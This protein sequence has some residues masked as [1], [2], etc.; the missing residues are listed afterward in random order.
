MDS[1]QIWIWTLMLTASCSATVCFADEPVQSPGTAPLAGDAKPTP[2]PAI[3]KPATEAA[4]ASDAGSA[5]TPT[6]A[7]PAANAGSAKPPTEAAPVA[8][9]PLCQE[10][11]PGP[12]LESRKA[13][14]ADIKKA[15]AQGVGIAG[16]LT[17]FQGIEEQIKAG[18]PPDQL[19]GRID[20][21]KR[22]LTEQL[23]RSQL[24]KVQKPAP[25]QGS[26]VSGSGSASSA[27]ASLPPPS[28]SGG[29]GPDESGMLAKLKRKFGDLNNI[30]EDQIP[31]Q[32][33]DKLKDPA[34]R[35]KLLDKFGGGGN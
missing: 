31:A 6:E 21:I 5:K 22:S 32:F 3:G 20:S 13:L 14:M 4:P 17:A 33:R 10:I 18:T 23:K 30:P 9:D 8:K 24:L 27:T 26:Q 16:Y 35:Q 15:K 2:D 34:V 28:S 1:K 12:L 7:A 19:T 29:P 25:P 11:S